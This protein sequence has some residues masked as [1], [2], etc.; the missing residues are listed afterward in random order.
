MASELLDRVKIQAEVVVPLLRALREELGAERANRIAWKALERWRTRLV[1]ELARALPAD[2]SNAERFQAY[3]RAAL[4]GIGDAL[5]FTWLSGERE[6]EQGRPAERLEFDVTNCRFAQFFRELGE[7]EL[8]FAMLC[9]LDNTATDEV[10]KGD[11]EFTRTQTI[12][13]GGAR[14]D[15][16]YALKRKGLA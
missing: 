2:A 1:R 10:G 11:V 4:P 15:F 3:N 7:P 16:R 6:F 8:G 14:C 5:E 12:M 9:S 13:Q